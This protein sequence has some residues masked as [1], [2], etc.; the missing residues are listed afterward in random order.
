MFQTI[1]KNTLAQGV[2]KF[3]VILLSIATTALLTRLLGGVEGYGRYAFLTAFVL[4]FGT[5]SDWGT[6][7]IAVREASRTNIG[8]P[9]IFG[10]VTIFRLFFSV[11]ALLLLNLVVRL[12][13]N[14]HEFVY[15]ATVASLVLVVLSLKT[16]SAIVFQTLL[17]MENTAVTEIV[18]S[19]ALLGLVFLGFIFNGGIAWLMT[20][21]VLATLIASLVSWFLVIRLTHIVWA[22]DWSVARS[23]VWEALPAGLLLVVSSIYNRIDTIILQHFQ[24]AA[25]VGIYALAYKVHDNLVMGSAF[26]MNAVLPF[27]SKKFVQKSSWGELRALY[28]KTFDLLLGFGVF[29]FI[30]IFI[31]SPL[32]IGVLGGPGFDRS[33][34]VLRILLLSTFF[35][36]FNHLTGYSLLA[37]GRQRVSL[38]IAVSALVFNVAANWIFIPVYS[39]NAAAVITIATEGFVL[40]LSSIV[41]WRT[42]GIFPSLFSITHTWTELLQIWKR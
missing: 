13:P 25:D 39:Y 34:G 24:G 38:V 29:I 18:S 5:L 2:G 4:L 22:V 41:V 11:A 20:A 21:W 14:W 27:L 31:L 9:V 26:L 15:P 23:V 19:V 1:I 17:K 3:F 40:V 10:S 37:F 8:R 6:T 42:I 36:Y 32:I 30:F 28:Q 12:N 7:P 35:A 16:S 33:A